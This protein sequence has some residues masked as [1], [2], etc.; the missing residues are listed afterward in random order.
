MGLPKIKYFVKI[1]VI[2]IKDLPLQKNKMKDSALSIANYFIDKAKQC[3]EPIKPLRLM[4][5][6]YIAHGFMLALLDRSALN[7]RFDV[8]EA[9]K[10]GP[11]VPSIYHTFKHY[12]DQPITQKSVVFVGE[13][14]DIEF[15]EPNL[16]DE[17]YKEV[18]DFVWDRYRAYNDSDLVSLTHARNTP[19]A[20]FYEEG[21]NRIIPDKYTKMYYR[22]LVNYLMNLP[23][24][25]G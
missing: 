5:L 23:D 19:W 8:V 15:E 12:R 10:F 9:W 17:D 14:G 25:Q 2:I 18:C 7:P 16:V 1:C 24:E 11:V 3:N 6:V 4:K 20:L 22:G 13:D 21:K